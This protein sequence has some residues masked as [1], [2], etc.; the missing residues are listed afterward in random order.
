VLAIPCL[1][2]HV[3]AARSFTGLVLGVHDIDD[4]GIASLLVSELVT[5]S[6]LHSD[7]AKPGGTVTITVAVAPGEVLIEVTDNGGGGEPVPRDAGDEGEN[8]RGLHLVRE[9]AGAWGH[10]A[11]DGRLTTW[12]TLNTPRQEASRR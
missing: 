6:V 3:H 9:L 5:N 2:E 12:F 8:G 1:P 10:I 11:A 4:D 7:S